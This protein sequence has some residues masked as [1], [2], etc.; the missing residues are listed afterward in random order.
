M[1]TR[2]KQDKVRTG[3]GDKGPANIRIALNGSPAAQQK[4]TRALPSQPGHNIHPAVFPKSQHSKEQVEANC[5]AA[6]KA[7][8]EQ[9][10]NAKM[11][12]DLLTR[13]NI[14]EDNEEEDLPV[15]YP[16]CL[17][18]RIDKRY[19]AGIET[20]SDECF[21]IRVNEEDSNLDSLPESDKTTEAKLKVS[22]PYHSRPGQHCD[23]HC[24]SAY[25]T[26]QRCSS[27]GASVK[28]EGIM[29]YMLESA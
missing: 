6:L 16:P 19:H 2:A 14:L 11:A 23:L 7:S 26:R 24:I 17:S 28:D 1:G 4:P 27:S 13:M 3:C 29:L 25:K 10:P 8:E 22:V 5:K 21:D 9:A 20:E 12:M 15:Q 18:A